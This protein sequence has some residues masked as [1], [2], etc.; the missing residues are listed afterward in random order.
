MDLAARVWEG[1]LLCWHLIGL[2]LVTADVAVASPP[3]VEA[4]SPF[5]SEAYRFT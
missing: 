5:V 4:A 1:G 3:A 2:A